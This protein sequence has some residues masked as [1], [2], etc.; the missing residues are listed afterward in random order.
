MAL[1]LEVFEVTAP[2]PAIV[3]TDAVA[4]E[5]GRQASYEEGYRAGWEDAVKARSEEEAR[6]QAELARNLQALGFTFREARMHVLRG[7]EPLMEALVGR[8]LPDMARQMLAPL[9]LETLMPLADGMSE[10][11]VTLLV[12]PSARAC[13]ERLLDGAVAL[14]LVIHDE[15]SLDEG[16]ATIRLGVSE[17]QVDL[18]RAVTDIAAAVRSYFDLTQQEVRHG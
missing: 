17:T 16:Q 12:H 18:D 2:E 8:I 11:P 15:P 3:V 13:L 4:V 14:P 1:R 10:A 6:M 9:V 5:E 7:I